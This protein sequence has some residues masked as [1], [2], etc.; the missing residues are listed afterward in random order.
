[1]G[2]HSIGALS[3]QVHDITRDLVDFA[4]VLL[5]YNDVIF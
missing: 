5:V 4:R 1:M 2:V 3:T